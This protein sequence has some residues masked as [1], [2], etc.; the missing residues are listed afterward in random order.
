MYKLHEPELSPAGQ[1]EAYPTSLTSRIDWVGGLGG[2]RL[3]R[4][5]LSALPFARQPFCHLLLL[6]FF[7]LLFPLALLQRLRS[8]TSHM[9]PFL[10]R[11][12]CSD[13]TIRSQQMEMFTSESRARR[14]CVLSGFRHRRTL[15]GHPHRHR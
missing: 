14:R 9:L 4:T 1:A 10:R 8:T 13:G 5:A 12:A 11:S 15:P 2:G 3:I 7:A 6:L